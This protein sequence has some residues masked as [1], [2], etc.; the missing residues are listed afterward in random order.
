MLYDVH[1]TNDSENKSIYFDCY[2][3][4]LFEQE[5][6]ENTEYCLHTTKDDV[7]GIPQSFI[8]NPLMF[9]K[10]ITLFWYIQ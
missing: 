3:L 4:F 9:N 1:N 10:P 2:A 6:E 7:Y 5:L 8:Y